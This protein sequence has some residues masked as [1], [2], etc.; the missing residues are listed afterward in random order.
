MQD[1]MTFALLLDA[2][3][4]AA[5]L[6]RAELARRVG[7]Q[8]AAVGKWL[9]GV[10]DGDVRK[11]VL[12]NMSTL[13]LVMRELCTSDAEAWRMLEAYL[14]DRGLTQEHVQEAS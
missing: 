8:R 14:R 7:V 13:A 11:K 12:P 6:T 10:S 1:R 4:G 9:G 2:A 3:M 5:N